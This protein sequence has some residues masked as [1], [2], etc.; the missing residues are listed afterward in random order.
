MKYFSSVW[1]W[2]TNV[3]SWLGLSNKNAKMLLLGLDN[4]GKTTLLQCLKTG[5]FQQFEQTKTYQ[6]VDLTIEGIHFSAFDLG[7]HDI[8]RQSWQ[9]YYVN[10]NA[11]VFMVDAAAPDR[12]AEAKT[13]LDKL[14]S[15]ETLKNVPFLILGNK[16]DIPTAVSPDQLASSLGIFSQTDLQATTVPAGQRAIRIFMC[17]IKNKSGYAEGF[18]WLSKFI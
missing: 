17:S 5:N 6:I 2:L 1:N 18:R 10:A 4:A 14:L 11:I 8:A 3:L 12:F 15:D 9:D 7:G 13:E 16:V